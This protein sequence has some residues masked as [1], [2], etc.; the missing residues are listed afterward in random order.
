MDNNIKTDADN[1]RWLHLCEKIYGIIAFGVIAQLFG[2]VL[3]TFI[4]AFVVAGQGFSVLPLTICGLIL[5]VLWAAAEI[6]SSYRRRTLYA[7]AAPVIIAPSLLF[8]THTALPALTFS[9]FASSIVFLVLLIFIN[10]KYLWLEQQEGFPHF[11][12][13]LNE[14]QKLSQDIKTNDPYT[15]NYQRI[16]QNSSGE[17]Q[18][19]S[20]SGETIEKKQDTKNDYMDSI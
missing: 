10:K 20:L 8:D 5:P 6:Y 15:A 19:L 18:E 3:Y 9:M 1:L 13:L 14:Q 12:N 11:S 4:E 2:S 17:M 16:V 7:L